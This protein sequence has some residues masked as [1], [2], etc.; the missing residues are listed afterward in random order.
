[1]A[2]AHKIVPQIPISRVTPVNLGGNTPATRFTDVDAGKIVKLVGPDRFDLAEVGDPIEA[3]VVG[4]ENATSNG[5]KVGGIKKDEMAFVTADG[6]QADGAGNI[7]AGDYVVTGT[8]VA[9]Q[10]A[11]PGYPK[12]RKAT[13]QTPGVFAWRVVGIYEGTGAPGSILVIERV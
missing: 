6:G 8:V 10:T 7:A 3:I 5:Y 12:V 9:L 13:S 1:M 11:M 4:V 2:A